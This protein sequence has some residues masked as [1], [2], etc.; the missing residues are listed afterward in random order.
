MVQTV[1]VG[2]GP[3]AIAY[4]LGALWVANGGDGTVSKIEPT[5]GKPVRTFAAG[6]GASGITTGFGSVWVT[7]ERTGNV[8]RVDPRTGMVERT[9]NVGNGAGAIAVGAAPSGWPTTST[10]RSAGS[11]QRPTA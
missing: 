6:P 11:T 8:S 7:S 10:G 9:I 1:P 4:G 3:S 5:S 2:N